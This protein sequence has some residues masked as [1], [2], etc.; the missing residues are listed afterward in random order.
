MSESTSGESEDAICV[1]DKFI[2]DRGLVSSLTQQ[3]AIECLSTAG[4]SLERTTQLLRLTEDL[5]MYVI[6]LFRV[7]GGGGMSLS[8]F[9][10]YGWCAVLEQVRRD[11]DSMVT[12]H[13][14]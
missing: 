14:L 11:S 8:A 4:Y 2:S 9:C 5:T 3:E 10:L 7:K 13:C 12:A 1:V 6:S